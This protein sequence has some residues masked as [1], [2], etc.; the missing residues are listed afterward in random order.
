MRANSG[1]SVPELAKKSDVSAVSIY[2]IESGKSLN[3]QS[4]TR[5]RLEKA[6]KA[7][8]PTEVKE[9]AAEE[10]DAGTFGALTD[11][12]P[13][14]DEQLPKTAGVYV[15]YDVSER[16]VYVG[17]SD[18]IAK[19]VKAHADKFWFR[20]PIVSNA[21]YLKVDNSKMRHSIEQVLIKFLKSNAVINKQSVDR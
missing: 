18:N 20:P 21:A 12:D 19:R 9:E 17:K 11:F 8:V 15:L 16:P 10:Q 14:N 2:N 5:S 13:Y 4:E 6:L 1:L 3:P 7:K